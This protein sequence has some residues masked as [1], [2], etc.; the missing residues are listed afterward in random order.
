MQVVIDS[1]RVNLN[2]FDVI[3]SGGEGLVV[4]G[5]I[6]TKTQ[7]IKVYHKPTKLRSTK[8]QDFFGKQWTLPQNR[9]AVPLKPVYNSK[10][11]MII[12]LTMPLIGTGFEDMAVLAN[13]KTRANLG[14]TTQDVAKIFLDGH[15]TLKQIHSNGLVVGDLSDLNV[16]FRQNKMLWIDVDAWQ[17]GRFPCPVAAIEFV[18]PSLYGINYS[19]APVFKTEN[20]WYSFAVLLFRSLTLVHPYGGTHKKVRAFER[21]AANKISVFD[22]SV[23]YPKIAISPDILSD[24]LAHEFTEIFQQGKRGEF[25]LQMLETY[26]KSLRK[27]SNCGTWF[28]K[29]RQGCPVCNERSLVVISRPVIENKNIRAL[30]LFRTAGTIIYTKVR[31]EKVYAVVHE[32]NKAFLY[33]IDSTGTPTKKDLFKAKKGVRY[34]IADGILV[35]NQ[36][37][38]EALELYD[39]SG[40]KITRFSKTNTEIFAPSRKAAFQVT[41]SKVIRIVG[42]TIMAGE[43]RG[44]RLIERQIRNGIPNQTW[45]TANN[46]YG[47]NQLFGLVQVLAEQRFW[48][49]IDGKNF[50]PNVTRLEDSES[51]IDLSVKFSLDGVVL[52]RKTQEQGENYLRVDVVDNNGLVKQSYRQQFDDSSVQVMH[53]QV[54]SGD[55]LLHASDDGIVQENIMTS[56]LKTFK[57][58]EPFVQEGDAL[59][60]F[61]KGV[62]VVSTNSITQLQLL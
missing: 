53:G 30:E 56:S 3:G 33:V 59:L 43:K 11:S 1:K 42:G 55:S 45:F 8:L 41:G 25:P 47:G 14:I 38:T 4:K 40:S 7:A 13:K 6:G 52:R 12:G 27:C 62:M 51:L 19:R 39:I 24:D 44:D 15:R 29:N 60:K 34:A 37:G 22:P 18:D 17:F 23:K 61:G 5:R 46:E 9:I 20:D 10:K 32:G 26:T 35:V 54:F 48:Y 57:Q 21:R 49:H 58:T 50:E 36:Q 2:N 31:R 28:P 16:L